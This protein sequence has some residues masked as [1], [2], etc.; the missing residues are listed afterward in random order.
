MAPYKGA[1]NGAA[2]GAIKG[3]AVRG[4]TLEDLSSYAH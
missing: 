2:Y 4:H 1:V 3:A